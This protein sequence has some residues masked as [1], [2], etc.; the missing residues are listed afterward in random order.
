MVVTAVSVASVAA[1]VSVDVA[2]AVS[3]DAGALPSGV[4]PAAADVAAVVDAAVV[5]AL[6][7]AVVVP[8]TLAAL[9]ANGTAVIEA[10]GAAGVRKNKYPTT[11]AATNTT[12]KPASAIVLKVR[13]P[14]FPCA[15]VRHVD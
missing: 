12:T 14:V 9:D 10:L 3:A 2:A 4:T 8:A 15:S 5:L 1:A 11:P 7:D 13:I 6:A